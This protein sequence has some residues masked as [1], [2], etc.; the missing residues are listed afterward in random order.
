MSEKKAEEE[1]K[2]AANN[3]EAAKPAPAAAARPAAPAPKKPEPKKQP[4]PVFNDK[5]GRLLARGER[6]WPTDVWRNP[7]SLPRYRNAAILL[8]VIVLG[9]LGLSAAVGEIAPLAA[10]LER[11]LGA[12]VLLLAARLGLSAGAGAALSAGVWMMVKV[13][14]VLHVVALAPIFLVWWERKIAAH[15]Q[16]RLG[17]MYVGGFHGWLQTVAD[18]IKLLLKENITP[19]AAD[20]WV[21]RLA[22]VV[23]VAPA[24]LAF[25][26]VMFG[27]D[28]VAAD[29][30]VGVLY[31][32]AMAGISVVGI[33]MAGWASGNKYSLLG[34][35]RSAAQLVSY[36]LP[37]TFSIVPVLM[38]AGSLNLGVIAEAQ[39]GYWLGVVPRWYVFYPVVGQLAFIIF[40]IASV[41]ETNRIPFDIPE[42]ES[43]LVAGFHTEYS[44]MKFSLFFLAEYAYVLL[45]CCLAA[46]FFLGGGA[47]PLPAL[48]FIPSWT[49]FL[50]KVLFLVFCF[51]WFRW[52]FPR[53]R[54]DRLMDFNW[55]FLLPWTFANIALAGLYVLF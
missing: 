38:F 2:A 12:G 16:S 55:K 44:G 15:I 7:W 42:A 23:V 34:G 40:M 3:H 4:D 54:V 46:A 6:L 33:M 9:G 27:Q 10:R 21:H 45:A 22:P 24:I 36:E 13:L 51:L 30:D 8:A 43:E 29:I 35:L 25:A 41:A 32:F 5:Q 11:W 37:R 1:K 48:A 28:L 18:G 47:A 53:F 17:P 52:T 20:P 50:A 19:D 31:I 39:A 14:V 49:W 26:P